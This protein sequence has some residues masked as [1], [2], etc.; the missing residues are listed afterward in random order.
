MSKEKE[1]IDVVVDCLNR[2]LLREV[3]NNASHLL[4]SEIDYNPRLEAFW[5]VGGIDPPDS[6]V[7]RR[8]REKIL[9]E[10]NYN[11]PIDRWVQYIGKW[12][13]NRLELKKKVFE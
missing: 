10:E 9:D 5:C 11:D 12:I 1:Q 13:F 6:V 3:S 8:K 2:V 4:E 7:K